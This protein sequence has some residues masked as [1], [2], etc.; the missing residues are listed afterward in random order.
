M[1]HL[2]VGVR[3]MLNEW[4]REGL[5]RS[6]LPNPNK[7]YL[8][9]E[10]INN[11]N[12]GGGINGH[13]IYMTRKA[14]RSGSNSNLRLR[15]GKRSSL[16]QPHYEMLAMGGAAEDPRISPTGN[17][18]SADDANGKSGNWKVI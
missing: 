15:Y 12:V 7:A 13:E 8:T 3:D 6:L 1:F 4:E 5:I 10:N 2:L 9:N 14:P 17:S 18:N 11:N 16:P